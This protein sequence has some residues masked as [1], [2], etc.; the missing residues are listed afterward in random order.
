LAA[1]QAELEIVSYPPTVVKKAVAGRGR[2][3]KEQVARMVG[4][5][6]GWREL[7]A[8]DATDALAV[9]IAHAQTSRLVGSAVGAIP[10]GKS[11]K[12]SR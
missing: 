2:A 5:I 7:P 9:A 12:T 10:R 6:L 4:A 8:I 11:P 1:G 3:S